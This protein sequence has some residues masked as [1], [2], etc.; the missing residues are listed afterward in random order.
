MTRFSK[1]HHCPNFCGMKV[2]V[3][4]GNLMVNTICIIHPYILDVAFREAYLSW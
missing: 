2:N 1:Y 3:V 4:V